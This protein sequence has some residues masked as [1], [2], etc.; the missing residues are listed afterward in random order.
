MTALIVISGL[1]LITSCHAYRDGARE[2]S[3]YN[4]SIEHVGAFVR[5][6]DEGCRYFLIVKEVVNEATLELGNVTTSYECGKVYGS[7]WISIQSILS[8]S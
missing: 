6:C 4:H 1:V 2:E 3:C 5:E 8:D 7:K